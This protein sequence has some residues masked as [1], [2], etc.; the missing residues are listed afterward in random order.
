MVQATEMNP[1]RNEN[2]LEPH[3]EPSVT[4]VKTHLADCFSGVSTSSAI[5]MPI[6]ART[7]GLESILSLPVTTLDRA[8]CLSAQTI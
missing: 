4:V 2:P 1:R 3:P 6:D 8:H 7:V 5:Q